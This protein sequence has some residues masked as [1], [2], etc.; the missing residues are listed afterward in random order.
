MS[1]HLR[2]SEQASLAGISRVGRLLSLAKQPNQAT[3]AG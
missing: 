2:C 3:V 1:G